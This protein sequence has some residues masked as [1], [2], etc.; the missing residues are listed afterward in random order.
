MKTISFITQKGGSGKSTLV[1]MCAVVAEESGKK[2]L[3]IDTDPQGTAKDWYYDRPEDKKMPHLISISTG[4]VDKAIELAKENKFDYVLIDTPG[5]DTPGIKKIIGL[6]DFIVIPCRPAVGD[7]RASLPSV[8]AVNAAGK[9]FAFV[10]NQAPHQPKRGR[11]AI[12]KLKAVGTVCPIPVVY[13]AV[14]QDAQLHGMGVSEFE[15]N[16]KAHSEVVSLWKWIVST[17]NKC[18]FF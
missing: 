11:Q 4:E 17:A 9:K 3:I 16:G 10:V 6:S 13:R 14:F 5:R 2:T 1:L 8:S 18:N 12:D 15:T 7:I